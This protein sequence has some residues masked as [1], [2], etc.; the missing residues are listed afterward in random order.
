MCAC[1]NSG[2]LAKYT[3]YIKDMEKGGDKQKYTMDDE[4]SL[5]IHLYNDMNYKFTVLE[6]CSPSNLAIREHLWIQKL[7][8]LYP[9]G[10]NL[11]SP[12][13]LPLLN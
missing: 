4:Y 10:L 11:V 9:Y 2:H 6:N 13:G 3:K 7:R 5:G 12:F 8:T 1:R